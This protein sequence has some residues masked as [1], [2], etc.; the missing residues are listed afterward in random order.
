M[1][2]FFKNK[3]KKQNIAGNDRYFDRTYYLQSNNKPTFGNR[4]YENFAYDGYMSNII[5]YRAINMISKAVSSIGI[6]FYEIE[7]NGEKKELNENDEIVKLLKQPNPTETY[8]EFIEKSVIS[9]LLSGNIYIQAVRGENDKIDEMY[10]LRS[11]RISIAPGIGNIPSYY[12]YKIG[13]LTFDFSCDENTGMSDILHIK[14][15]NPLDDW[16][17]L[18]PLEPAQYSIE[19]HNECIKWNKSLLENGARPCGA[20]IVKQNMTD[21]V[22]NR[23]KM[24]MDDNFKSSENAGKYMILEGGVDWKEM[25]VSPKDMD[26]IETK[27]SS[28]RDIAM[29]FGIQPQLLGIKGDA[30]YN[31]IKEARLIFWEDTVLPITKLFLNSISK[32]LSQSNG[33]QIEIEPDLDTIQ[34]LAEKRQKTWETMN[35]SDFVSDEEKR[36]SLG[37]DKNIEK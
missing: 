15:F 10:L 21:E 27:N 7:K 20:L 1:A 16:Y 19:Q 28:A 35:N 12:R 23:L 9:Y 26:Y 37:F 11:D 5:V 33:R 31:N 29:A 13:N 25:G 8:V 24:D 2:L 22:Y 36:E 30:T 3:V 17:G 18:S 32:W 34:S 4:D 6:C 14:T